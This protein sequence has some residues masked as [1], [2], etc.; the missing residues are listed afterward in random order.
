MTERKAELELLRLTRADGAY[1]ASLAVLGDRAPPELAVLGNPASLEA[2]MVGLFCSST[3]PPTAVLEVYDLARCLR[4][5]GVTVVGG[6]QSFG[7]RECLR[8]LL[9]GEQTVVVCPARGLGGMRL[10]GEWR[11][12]GEAGRLVLVSGCPDRVRR[13]TAPVAEARNRLVMAL[14]SVL[15]VIHA[16][17][18]GRLAKAVGGGLAAGKRVLCLELPE[19]E[20][21]R[22]AGAVPLRAEGVVDA[23]WPTR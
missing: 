4:D 17:P 18:G 15:V 16:T 20:D 10:P 14:A 3:L 13:P 7:E 21:L 6:F 2:R 22:V 8:F 1:P 5:A 23:L 11:A 9:R 12:A 19:N